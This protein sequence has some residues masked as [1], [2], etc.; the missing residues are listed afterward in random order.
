MSIRP[1]V[2]EETNIGLGEPGISAKKKAEWYRWEKLM[3]TYLDQCIR[4]PHDQ[5]LL[6]SAY[7]EMTMRYSF[8][9]P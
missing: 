6:E 7:T 3:T 2:S 4:A 9:A 1:K 5:T 8:R